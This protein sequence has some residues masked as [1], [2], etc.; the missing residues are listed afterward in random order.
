MCQ[1]TGIAPDFIM[2]IAIIGHDGIEDHGP[3]DS[4][5][6]D[7]KAAIRAGR[8]DEAREIAQQNNLMQISDREVLKK[9]LFLSL[10]L[11]GE[12]A[13]ISILNLLIIVLCIYNR[14]NVYG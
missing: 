6:S 4:F 11:H 7:W 10:L 2:G 8:Y 3:V 13:C 9:I 1:E 12:K 14:M 5:L